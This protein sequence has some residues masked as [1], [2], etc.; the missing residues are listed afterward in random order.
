[1]P[2]SREPIKIVFTHSQKKTP[3]AAS[4]EVLKK[5]LKII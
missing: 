4:Y 5:I 3:I 2:V 1:M